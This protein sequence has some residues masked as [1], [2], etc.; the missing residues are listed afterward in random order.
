LSVSDPDQ[1]GPPLRV[2][3][4]EFSANWGGQEFRVI[5]Q[6]E[7]LRRA[8]HKVGLACRPDSEIAAWARRRDLAVH[9]LVFRG[10]YNPLSMALARALVVREGYQVADCHGLRD[11]VAFA[12]ARG[13]CAVVRT[14]HVTGMVKGGWRHRLLWHKACDHVVATAARIKE[15][16]IAEGLT[17]DGRISVIGEWAA[18][19][20]FRVEDKTRHRA[21]V[22]AEFGLRPD[23][24]MIVNV[25]MLRHDKG[26]E[27]LIEAGARLREAG[28]DAIIMLVGGSTAQ[29]AQEAVSH[30][31]ILRRRVAELGMAERVIFAGYRTDVVRLVQA[32]DVQV[33][34]SV[35]V[36]GQSR[37]VPQAF[38]AGVPVVATRMGGLPELVVHERTG[39]L[40]APRDAAAIAGA[41]GDMLHG[42]SAVASIVSAAR[43][44]ALSHL[45]IEA[46]MRETLAL[47][48]RL[49]AARSVE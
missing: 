17:D 16:L 42:G 29:A 31:M 26:Q 7:W 21:E 4:A 46:K 19:E 3:H 23:R 30:E 10:V 24:P 2:L 41:V 28:S 39:L 13:A 14:Q 43:A 35:A 11:A 44:F 38:A 34:A 27:F 37:T 5:E 20:F 32:A 48:R 25:G 8:G 45:S 12:A 15:E 6:M 40:V 18:D 33:V 47:Y 9:P 49:I 1:S 36:E 22:R